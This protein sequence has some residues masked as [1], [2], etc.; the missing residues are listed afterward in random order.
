L[1]EEMSNDRKKPRMNADNDREFADGVMKTLPSVAV[2]AS[3]EARILADFDTVVA[4]L[5]R[6][7][8]RLMNRWRDVVW[9]GAPMWK[10]ASIF[11]I[12]LLAGLAA[13]AMVPSTDLPGT[14]SAQTQTT[15]STDEPSPALDMSKDL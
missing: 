13:G 12:S 11:A 10:P 9:P 4:R 1:G 3:L 5:S 14:T 8:G 6:R 7:R 2:P 15:A